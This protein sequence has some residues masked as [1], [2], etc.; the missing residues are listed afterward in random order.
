[1]ALVAAGL[2]GCRAAAPRST[3][4]REVV[5]ADH[6]VASGAG[7]EMLRRGGNAVDAAVATSFA[8]SVVRPFSCG[9]GGGGFMVC[10]FSDAGLADQA[11]LGRDPPRT[12]AINYREV[13]PASVGPDF[14][15][16][17]ENEGASERGGRS[18][19]VPGTVAGL[20]HAL[21]AYGTL[22]RATVL[23][24][25]IR[26]A[27]E[28]FLVDLAYMEMAAELIED[29]ESSP[30]WK[31]RFPFVWG[32]ML[33]EGR[34]GE[35][36]RIRLPEQAEALRLIARGGA[37]AF[38]SG[39]I[40]R[41]IVASAGEDGGVLTLIDLAGYRVAEVEPL[42]FEFAG[43][44]LLTMPP[45]SSG[46]VAMGQALGIYQRLGAPDRRTLAGFHGLVES[47][48]H[49]FADRAEWLGDPGFVEVPAGR[50]LA[51]EYLDAR[52]TAI[53]PERALSPERYGTRDASR[54][55]PA[56][57]P[58]DGGTSHISVVDAAGN[59]V[60]C[61]ETINLE[62]GS[63]VAVEAWGFLLNDEM[64]DFTTVRGRPNAFGLIQG[65]RNSPAPGKRP[66][67]SMTP[68]IV[69]GADG[70]VEVVAGASGG[71]RIITATAQAILA[72][73]LEGAGADEAVARPRWHHQWMPDV[74]RVEE[75]WLGA[76]VEGFRGD[77]LRE[78]L[79]GQG[80]Q[81]AITDDVGV[82]QLIR[83][84]R[85]GSGWEAACDPRK[86]GRPAGR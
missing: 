55:A 50:L 30:D 85:A 84:A 54:A 58:N 83:R 15:E 64:D 76:G 12:V 31:T 43:R 81:L 80:H 67:S 69:V 6:A 63:L 62:F 14:Y 42:R 41:A 66:L 78:R 2:T 28:G 57:G 9:I 23:A 45:P 51:G 52:S 44:E 61:T 60:A 40:A 13:A 46:G 38:Y 37:D 3:F 16:R 4:D 79:A 86:G 24:P 65:E 56:V 47:F 7:A 11:R 68:T 82:V 70:G 74:L 75:C 33:N 29:F 32:R 1:M 71:P 39:P 10:Y 26:A 27:E 49:A 59:A 18:I 8:L 34:V 22:D 72:C 77:E 35:G 20:L 17:P 53:D 73:V 48:K 19:G 36:D 21:A 25:A 5:A